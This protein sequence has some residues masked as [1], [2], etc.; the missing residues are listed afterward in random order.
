MAWLSVG[1][2]DSRVAT[3]VAVRADV[4]ALSD[5]VDLV[6]DDV[7][8]A[9]VRLGQVDSQIEEVFGLLHQ[10]GRSRHNLLLDQQLWLQRDPDRQ[11]ERY[12]PSCTA[13]SNLPS[14]CYQRHVNK[15]CGPSARHPWR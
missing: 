13:A 3:Q 15:D 11:R 5:R 10:F 9:A 14:S 12:L 7:D 1:L 2:T 4:A 6:V 8:A